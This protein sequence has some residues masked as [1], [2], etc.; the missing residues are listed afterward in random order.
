MTITTQKGTK[1]V[2][3]V[4][5]CKSLKYE[6]KPHTESGPENSDG[7]VGSQAE[8]EVWPKLVNPVQE[9]EAGQ[10]LRKWLTDCHH[11]LLIAQV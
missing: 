6:H 4:R 2:F 10:G 7:L 11:F 1:P 9:Q 8:A 3:R 5:L